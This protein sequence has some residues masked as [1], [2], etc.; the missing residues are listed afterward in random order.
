MAVGGVDDDDVHPRLH[1]GGDPLLGVSAHAHGGA[2]PQAALFIL[3]GVGIGAG[4]VDVLH[5][6]QAPQLKGFVDHQHPLQTVT[7]HQLHGLFPAGAFLHGHQ[8]LPGGHD[9]RHRLVQVGLEAQIPVGDDAN[10]LARLVHHRQTGN[11]ALAGDLQ[12]VAHGHGGRNGD[13]ILHHAGFVPLHP[14]HPGS[15]LGDVEI[16]V[17]DAQAA[18]LGQGDGHARFGH[19]VHGGG[20]DRHVQPDLAGQPGRQG[21]VAGQDFGKGGDEQDVVESE[22]FLENTHREPLRAKAHYTGATGLAQDVVFIYQIRTSAGAK[23]LT[24]V[25]ARN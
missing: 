15:L 8:A 9:V 13:R 21:N 22:G 11:L 6:H 7:V 12:H 18:L 19:R 24:E 10:H 16:L 5:G 3:A 17:D 23:P 2:C 25:P 1:Q 20:Q 4:L 14:G